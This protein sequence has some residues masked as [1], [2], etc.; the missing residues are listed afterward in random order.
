MSDDDRQPERILQAEGHVPP[1]RSR[2]AIGQ[3][4]SGSIATLAMLSGY[5]GLLGR[6]LPVLWPCPEIC[7]RPETGRGDWRGLGLRPRSVTSKVSASTTMDK[8][9]PVGG[10][11]LVASDR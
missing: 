3:P 7:H 2:Y 10:V 9:L 6:M 1:A 5:A 11:P 4:D 8:Y